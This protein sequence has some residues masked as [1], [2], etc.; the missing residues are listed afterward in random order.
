[1]EERGG[2]RLRR[3]RGQFG[4]RGR[5]RQEVLLDGLELGARDEGLRRDERIHDE[6]G[7]DFD[8]AGLADEVAHPGKQVRPF[9]AG[10]VV[11]GGDGVALG[12]GDIGDGLA[13]REVAGD[14]G[15]RGRRRLAATVEQQVRGE[16]RQVA[17]EA[18]KRIIQ[19]GCGWC[20]ALRRL[21]G[22]P[23]TLKAKGQGERSGFR[24]SRSG[25]CN[26]FPPGWEPRLYV[27]QR[28]LTPR[29]RAFTRRGRWGR[30]GSR[31]V[32][33]HERM[34]VVHRCGCS[35]VMALADRVVV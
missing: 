26:V 21:A 24:F 35:E 10:Q 34:W 6:R 31:S 22:G 20:I 25:R 28:W 7:I 33:R 17:A 5:V 9:F 3:W 23:A 32:S 19:A 30:V 8:V 1:M 27:S 16:E 14:E 11:R 13:V 2:R 12:A 18:G 4:L 29:A 15:N